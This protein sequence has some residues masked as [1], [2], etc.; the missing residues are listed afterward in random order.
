MTK[1]MTTTRRR[2]KF[3]DIAWISDRVR[4]NVRLLKSL[5]HLSDAGLADAGGFTSRQVISNRLSG[6][7][8][9]DTEDIARLASALRVEPHVLMLRPDEAMTWVQEHGDF[10]PPH[11]E[12]QSPR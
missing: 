6:R 7:T 8:P 10:D 2:S 3:A 5:R 12:P 4:T 11:Y 9:F 1:V